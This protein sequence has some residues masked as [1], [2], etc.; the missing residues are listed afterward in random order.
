M[1]AMDDER[2]PTD[3]RVHL[4]VQLRLSAICR[5]LASLAGLV[6]MSTQP[7]NNYW[8]P[9][10]LIQLYS[11]VSENYNQFLAGRRIAAKLKFCVHTAGLL[12]L[13]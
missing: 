1:N 11:S 2:R 12:A 7:A 9:D 13:V 3:A 4:I 10:I 8:Q 5:P 6:A